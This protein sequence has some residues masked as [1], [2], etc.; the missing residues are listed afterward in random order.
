MKQKLISL[1]T[2]L[3]C[4]CS[5][6]WGATFTLNS[7][8]S[9]SDPLFSISSNPTQYDYNSSWTS[10]NLIKMN[11]GNTITITNVIGATITAITAEGV[12]DNNSDKA[13]TFTITDGT[14]TAQTSSGNWN[15]RKSGSMTSKDFNATNVG[16]LKMGAGQTYTITN[17]SS[18]SYNAGVRFIITYTPA[19]AS[20]LSIKTQPESAEYLEGAAATALTVEAQ[21]G[22]SPYSYQW[23][24]CDDAEKTNASPITGQTLSSYTPSTSSTGYYYCQVTDNA[25]TPSV[26][27]SNVATITVSTA[28]APTISISS[29][30][31][32]AVDKGTT[33]TL[34]ATAT[35]KPT[36]SIQWYSNTVNNNT[37]GVAILGATE[38]TYQPSTAVGG[39]MYYYAVATNNYNDADHT[40]TSD[41]VAVEVNK[42]SEAVL[43][44]VVYSNSFDAFI[45]EPTVESNGKIQAYYMAGTSVP[46]I[47]STNLSDGATYS[48][49]GTTFTITA[50]DGVTTAV[51]DVSVEAVE[52]YT[53]VGEY[54]FDGT[55]AWVKAPYGFSSDEGKLGYKFSKKD[56]DWSRERPGKT[57]MYFFLSPSTSIK[58]ESGLSGDKASARSIKVYRDGENEVTAIMPKATDSPN[59]ITVTGDAN[60]NYMIAIVSNQTGGDGAIKS[61]TIT[62][63]TETVVI[64]SGKTF[65]TFNSEYN[66]DFTS[67]SAIT[68]YT[69]E[70]K[71]DVVT[72]T[73]VTTSVPA[74]TGLLLRG[75]TPGASADVSVVTSATS[76]TTNDFVAVTTEGGETVTS[77]YILA[78]VDGIQGFYPVNGTSGNHVAKG[79]AYLA[80]GGAG[81]RLTMVFDDEEG[82]ELTG[83]TLNK[84]EAT[85]NDSFYNLR[86]QRV[87]QPQKGLY[88]LN[89]KK[90]VLK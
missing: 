3:L 29:D 1:L 22:T 77:G 61:I 26:I 64:P 54:V 82:G 44:Q 4:V 53:G 41:V 33:V 87:A 9:T 78:T 7:S 13:V 36:P 71:D 30:A 17:M 2:L 40:A 76:P 46:T 74:H 58:L 23:Y 83:I 52:P 63:A 55:E 18:G 31:D 10:Y 27:T 79:K 50:E 68:A 60:G 39:T 12:A 70:V 66:L 24:S 11:T 84:R 16:K 15:N 69:A 14:T 38:Q 85:V 88:I 37:T 81:A 51:Y 72:L 35:G 75:A 57:R 65:A 34:T 49:V 48:L 28:S 47:S 19:V 62:P 56:A 6:A 59:Y 67:S 90:V 8:T 45:T 89:G 80:A 21:G 25:A 86:G 5:G 73:K 20:E 32:A 42:S 43:N